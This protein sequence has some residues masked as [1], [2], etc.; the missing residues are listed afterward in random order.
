MFPPPARLEITVQVGWA[1][2]LHFLVAV[3]N[4]LNTKTHS[5]KEI[6]EFSFENADVKSICY[7]KQRME[8]YT[9]TFFRMCRKEAL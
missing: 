2:T 9:V 4:T 3:M 7:C 5:S 1:L 8:R 6:A